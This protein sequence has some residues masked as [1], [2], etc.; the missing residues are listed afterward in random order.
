MTVNAHAL[1]KKTGSEVK[2][3]FESV[4]RESQIPENLQTDAGKEFFSKSFQALMKNH[5]ITHFATASNL[6]AS[7][8]ERFNAKNA[9]VEVFHG[10]QHQ[11]LPGGVTRSVRRVIT[12]VITLV[13]K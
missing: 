13:L 4:L 8:V 3:A 9:N 6:K 5:S 2:E 11:A 12:A 10:P 7:V 1:K